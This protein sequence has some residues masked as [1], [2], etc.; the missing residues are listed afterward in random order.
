MADEPPGSPA[1]ARRGIGGVKAASLLYHDVVE[2]SEFESS[3]FAGSGAAVYKLGAAD[4]E[5]HL[6][7][8]AARAIG[9]PAVV[10]ALV[11]TSGV[12]SV[13]WLLTFDDGG[14]SALHP[15]ADML[16]ARGWRGHFFVTASRIGHR[17]FLDGSAIRALADAGHVI[18]SHSWSHPARFSRL[19]DA[20]MREEWVSSVRALEDII[21]RKV[22]VASVPG[23]FYSTAVARAADDSGIRHL[24][25]SEPILQSRVVGGCRVFG[26]Y[27]L[28]RS[29]PPDLAAAFATGRTWP[30]FVQWATWN[31]RKALKRAGGG[32]YE[33]VR[34]L[35]LRRS[36][37][38]GQA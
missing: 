22:T 23:G 10:D 3:G 32:S 21:G 14:I 18:G 29:S 17:G 27:S 5:S 28:R 16:A 13:P 30:R 38:N 37:G 6:S 9:E 31:G 26:R 2:G 20:D 4:F 8:L 34:E 25:T 35:L 11:A 1:L 7:A 36:R 33:R 24:F 12:D 15:T 19:D